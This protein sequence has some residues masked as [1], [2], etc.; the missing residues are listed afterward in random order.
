MA[1][2]DPIP[3]PITPEMRAEQRQMRI[4]RRAAEAAVR[5]KLWEGMPFP[6]ILGKPIFMGQ[7]FPDHQS[8]VQALEARRAARERQMESCGLSLFDR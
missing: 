4:T 5:A 2:G 8:Y 6:P 3:S 7:D 1:E